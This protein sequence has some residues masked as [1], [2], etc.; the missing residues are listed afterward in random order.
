VASLGVV[1]MHL[2]E[3]QKIRLEQEIIQAK[4]QLRQLH[5]DGCHDISVIKQLQ[6]TIERNWQLVGMI[7]EHLFGPAA[8]KNAH[9]T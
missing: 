5:V 1:D 9:K 7:D 8:S 6:E 2:L 4:E 3:A